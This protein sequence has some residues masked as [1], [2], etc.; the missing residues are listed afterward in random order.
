MTTIT[1]AELQARIARGETIDLIDVRTALEWNAGHAIGARHVPLGQL[2]PAAVVAAR[3]GRP[4]DPV[5]V[6]CASGA[7]SAAACAAFARAGFAQAVNV[8]G[9][10]SAWSRAGLPMERKPGAAALGL[11]RQVGLL[12]LVAA[13]VLF[14]TPCSPLTLWGPA[15]CPAT[16]AAPAP[17]AAA[18]ALDF[19]RDVV[20]ASATV[21]VLVDFHA[22]WCG[23]CKMM[24]P[25]LAALARE[26]GER[27]RVVPVDVDQHG[28]LARTHGVSSIPDVR[29]WLGGKEVARFAGFRPQAEIA[30]W[31]DQAAPAR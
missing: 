16:P 15:Y 6:I 24:A 5:Y 18:S 2:D 17:G 1:P 20:G 25:E 26:R 12:A 8:E 29:L 28:A 4:D 27:L 9:G 11:L 14:L 30:A 10:T 19:A 22:S 23:P 21:P 31:I 13:A 3:K 7:R